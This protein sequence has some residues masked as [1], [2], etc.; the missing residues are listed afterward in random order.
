MRTSFLAFFT[1]SASKITILLSLYKLS[2]VLYQFSGN[3]VSGKPLLQVGPQSPHPSPHKSSSEATNVSSS[4]ITPTKSVTHESKVESPHISLAKQ[5]PEM[6]VKPSGK[7][8]AGAAAGSED[9]LDVLHLRIDQLAAS[10]SEED[11]FSGMLP[12]VFE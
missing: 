8:E 6:E 5:Q 4:H 12:S 1:S 9:I 3:A 7:S 2:L 10:D 11:V